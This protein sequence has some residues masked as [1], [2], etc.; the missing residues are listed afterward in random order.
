MEREKPR[1][2]IYRTSGADKRQMRALCSGIE[3]EMIPFE[4][5]DKPEDDLRTLSYMAAESS[6]LEVGVAVGRNGAA[7]TYRKLSPNSPLFIL[8]GGAVNEE[9]LQKMGTNAARLVKGIAF[10]E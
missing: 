2:I 5:V 4:I 3:E 8:E 9:S 7:L 1:I 10:K 6:R